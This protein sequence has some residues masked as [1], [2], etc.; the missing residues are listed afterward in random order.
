MSEQTQ[1]PEYF[2]PPEEGAHAGVIA[3]LTL[4]AA[5]TRFKGVEMP[6]QRFEIDTAISPITAGD[7]RTLMNLPYEVALYEDGGKTV[8]NRGDET[9][10]RMEGATREA[11]W[12]LHTHPFG[13]EGNL[14]P[15][16]ADILATWRHDHEKTVHFLVSEKGITTYRAPQHEPNQPD[17]PIHNILRPLAL[18]GRG[19]GVNLLTGKD[20]DGHPAPIETLDEEA[21]RLAE[22]MGMIVDEAA[23]DD[24]RG[25]ERAL[26]IINDNRAKAVGNLAVAGF[27]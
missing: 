12:M 26:S 3:P 2:E 14:N 19:T 22:A 24:Q 18:W 15:S 23:W 10:A 8:L 21:R 27:E 17:I 1:P 7:L 4:M 9:G 5:V 13:G 25:M 16:A 20:D 11:R 6:G